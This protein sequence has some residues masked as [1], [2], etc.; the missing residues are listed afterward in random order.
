MKRLVTVSLFSLVAAVAVTTA[1]HAQIEIEET[2]APKVAEHRNGM[3]G[4]LGG[5]WGLQSCSVCPADRNGI[6]GT[7]VIGGSLSTTLLIGGGATGWVADDTAGTMMVTML[8]ARVRWYPFGPIFLSFGTGLGIVGDKVYPPAQRQ[9]PGAT[10]AEW[11]TSF[12]LGGG[13][14]LRVTRGFS[15]SPSV[16]YAAVKTENLDANVIQVGLSITIH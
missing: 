13:F 14:D 8:D 7:V 12:L 9:P 11:G 1:A 15:L 3:W 16:H 2:K 4:S 10:G 6:Y 5:G